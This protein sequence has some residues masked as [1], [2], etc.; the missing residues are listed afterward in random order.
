MFYSD[1]GSISC[2]FW[3]IQCRKISRPWNPGQVC[4]V[5][6]LIYYSIC[7]SC[8]FR[9]LL[10]C[11]KGQMNDEWTNKWTE[12]LRLILFMISVS[13]ELLFDCHRLCFFVNRRSTA[14]RQSSSHSAAVPYVNTRCVGSGERSK[15]ATSS[16]QKAACVV[17]APSSG[18]SLCKVRC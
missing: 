7:D 11:V 8:C 5:S 3:D 17:Y 12:L 4:L 18:E 13:W 1:Y 6:F 9:C 15:F 16:L 14:C 2:R 10:L